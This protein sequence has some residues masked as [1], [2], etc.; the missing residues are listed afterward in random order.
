MRQY[1]ALS[2]HLQSIRIRRLIRT[3]KVQIRKVWN[4]IRLRNQY[5]F[6]FV[7]SRNRSITHTNIQM[8][9]AFDRDQD[10]QQDSQ[11]DFHFRR[12]RIYSLSSHFFFCLRNYLFTSIASARNLSI[13]TMIC[14][15]I[16]VAV[17]KSLRNVDRLQ[18]WN[19]RFETKLE[20][21]EKIILRACLE[22]NFDWVLFYQ[23]KVIWKL[24]WAWH[25]FLLL[26]FDLHVHI[27]FLNQ[28]FTFLLLLFLIKHDFWHIQSFCSKLTKTQKNCFITLFCRSICSFVW[29]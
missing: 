28:I 8:F 22:R 14:H 25:I 26:T 10:F 9:F 21:D 19:N 1:S 13:S 27:C 17:I 15:A 18:K 24:M 29:K 12:L 6:A 2:R 7:C 20:K 11:Q 4:S 3:R 16:Y 5:R 23:R